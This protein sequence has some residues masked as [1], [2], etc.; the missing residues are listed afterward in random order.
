MGLGLTLRRERRGTA[1]EK[2]QPPE[3]SNASEHP[4]AKQTSW[5]CLLLCQQEG[6]G[7]YLPERE[8]G[9]SRYQILIQTQQEGEAA[10]SAGHTVTLPDPQCVLGTQR[11][12]DGSQ[13]L[14]VSPSSFI[15][16]KHPLDTYARSMCED[17]RNSV[18]SSMVHSRPRSLL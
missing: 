14:L 13:S 11:A 18:F 5:W 1:G 7:F 4:G 2:F 8:E 3:D 17:T 15:H 9:I 16:S 10:L 12:R 6:G